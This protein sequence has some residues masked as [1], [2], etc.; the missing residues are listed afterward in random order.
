MINILIG[1][2]LVLFAF[3]VAVLFMNRICAVKNDEKMNELLRKMEK[4]VPTKLEVV[5]LYNQVLE[6][7]GHSRT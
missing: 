7:D 4:V 6:D 1:G 2:G 3:F 5:D